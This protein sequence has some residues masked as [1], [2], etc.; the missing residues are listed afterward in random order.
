MTDAYSYMNSRATE[1]NLDFDRVTAIGESAGGHLAM[2]LG[3]TL[4]KEDGETNAFRSVF[5]IYGMSDFERWDRDGWTS[6]GTAGTAFPCEPDDPEDNS[7]IKNL[8]GGSC[9]PDA[10]KAISPVHFIDDNSPPTISI[11]GTMDSLVSYQQSEALHDV[12]DVA[13]VDNYLIT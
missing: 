11:H 7:L 6:G 2:L 1:F 5:N 13:G 8:A 10:L 4:K 9:A 12:L 3:Y